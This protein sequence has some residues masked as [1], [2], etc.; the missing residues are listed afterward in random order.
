MAASAAQ[1]FALSE[2]QIDWL[3][4]KGE[5]ATSFR[6]LAAFKVA[7]TKF[8]RDH[9]PRYLFLVRTCQH[10][11]PRYAFEQSIKNL[12]IDRGAIDVQCLGKD[13]VRVVVVSVDANLAVYDALGYF[14]VPSRPVTALAL[15]VDGRM[16]LPTSGPDT[17]DMFGRGNG[18]A[19]FD[20]AEILEAKKVTIVATINSQYVLKR[21]ISRY[22]LDS[23]FP[24]G[25]TEPAAPVPHD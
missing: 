17:F 7:G 12:D 24:S 5:T 8:R 25:P 4:N 20:P 15:K 11:V 1:S 18:A 9:E 6:T 10:W 2:F 23:L 22:V 3:I 13:L 21:K 16:V 19:L 14:P